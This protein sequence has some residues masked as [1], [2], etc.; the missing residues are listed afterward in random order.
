MEY[1]GRLVFKK[2]QERKRLRWKKNQLNRVKN[3][4]ASS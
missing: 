4:L 1:G 3:A 2:N